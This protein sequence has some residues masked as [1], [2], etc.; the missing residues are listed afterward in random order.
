MFETSLCTTFHGY[1]H[2][3][4]NMKGEVQTIQGE[5]AAGFVQV[6]FQE[7]LRLR[8]IPAVRAACK[9]AFVQHGHPAWFVWKVY[10][11]FCDAVGHI[12]KGEDPLFLLSFDSD[13]R[14]G[15]SHYWLKLDHQGFKGKVPDR[16]DIEP[17]KNG[18]IPVDKHKN[19]V[20]TAPKVP[21]AHQFAVE[22]L[23]ARAKT[24]YYKHLGDNQ[25][26]TP[27]EMWTS[28]EHA[29]RVVSCDSQT[30]QN[31]FQHGND[32]ML[33]FAAKRDT[34]L[35]LKGKRYYG[36]DGGWLPEDRRG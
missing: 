18:H 19:Y 10:Q 9:K 36:T 12:P 11:D 35:V 25:A 13:P 17:G 14:H 30:V 32:N 34:E 23:F 28:I 16:R 3:C 7:W 1:L 26:P 6:E 20:P 2:T 15:M 5:K 4:I 21:D 22:S 24:A 29:F 27:A 8:V 33:L 31:C